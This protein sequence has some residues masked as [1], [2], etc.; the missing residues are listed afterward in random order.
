LMFVGF[1][2]GT[3]LLFDHFGVNRGVLSNSPPR[4][5][6][7]E[8]CFRRILL[9]NTTL[10]LFPISHHTRPPPPLE[11]NPGLVRM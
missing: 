11:S 6:S 5:V 4:K 2:T 7:A 1:S 3:V 10:V 8:Y 9:I